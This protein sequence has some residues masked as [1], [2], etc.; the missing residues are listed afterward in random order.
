MAKRQVIGLN[1]AWW[2]WLGEQPA[3]RVADKDEAMA[4]MLT[5]GKEF[6]VANSRGRCDMATAVAEVL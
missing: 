1:E 5:Q 3:V 6:G 2:V 4:L